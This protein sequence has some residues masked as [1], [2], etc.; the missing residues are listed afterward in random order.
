MALTA[1]PTPCIAIL[2]CG[3]ADPLKARIRFGDQDVAAWRDLHAGACRAIA[4]LHPRVPMSESVSVQ[5]S[6][7][8][9]PAGRI[10]TPN[11]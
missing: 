9:K 6:S 8:A 4:G 10:V 3:L 5:R 7:R 1:V 11:R 2:W